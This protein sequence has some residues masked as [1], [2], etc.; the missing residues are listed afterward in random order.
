MKLEEIRKGYEETSGTFSSTLR[1]LAVSGTAIAWLFI[2]KKSI[3][4]DSILLI[5]ALGL[6][7]LTLIA[8]LLQNYILSI[9]WY[10][11]YKKKREEGKNEDCEVDEPESKNKWGWYLYHA[12]LGTLIIG[13]IL[14][15]LYVATTP[16]LGRIENPAW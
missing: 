8:D 9:K 10:N 15:V 3:N 2:T 6:C 4:E 1:T 13:Y 14:I 7:V 16:A 12:K 11:F 5:V